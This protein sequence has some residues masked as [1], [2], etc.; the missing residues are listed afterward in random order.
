MLS[1][2]PSD[3]TVAMAGLD[4]LPAT[5]LKVA[6]SL[7]AADRLTVRLVEWG[8]E[9][10]ALLVADETSYLGRHA[11]QSA[12]HDQVPSIRVNGVSRA[13][14]PIPALSKLATVRDFVDALKACLQGS[15]PSLPA[16]TTPGWDVTL[17]QPLLE[18]LRL[19][20]RR[21]GR[22]L[23]EWG[24]FRVISEPLGGRLHMLRRMPLDDLLERALKPD[25]RI[26]DLSD[27]D[28]Q[29]VFLPDV[30]G[31]HAIESL[32]WRLLPHLTDDDLPRVTDALRLRAW[33]DL[34]A[35][36]TPAAWPLVLAH[37]A[38]KPWTARDLASAIGV[39]MDEIQR[40]MALVRLSGLEAA[41]SQPAAGVRATAAHH[42]GT[43]LRMAK[44]FGLTLLGRAHG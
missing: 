35:G 9:P 25:W 38:S 13:S 30:T 23:I 42:A 40:V 24:L 15:A 32:W 4:L 7:L 18:H 37:L 2:L 16:D 3:V 43:L 11:I 17:P 33:P 12:R 10:A 44:R 29:T 28:W 21:P 34:D 26:T 41:P 36:A 27:K 6:C 31:S 39:P 8:T 22:V 20:R 14:D 1:P 19:D 5:R